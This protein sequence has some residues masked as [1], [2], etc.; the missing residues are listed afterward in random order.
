ML[1]SV[2]LR[3]V[4]PVDEDF[5]FEIFEQSREEEFGLSHWSAGEKDCFLRWQFQLRKTS[6]K[7]QFPASTQWIVLTD[8]RPVGCY[9]VQIDQVEIRLIDL[10]LLIQE[11]GKGIGTV[12]LQRLIEQSIKT[13]KPIRLHVEQ[14]NR[15]LHWYLRLGFRPF[16]QNGIYV[17]LERLSKVGVDLSGGSPG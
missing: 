13:D 2:F 8:Q 10:T 14:T 16:G 7:S 15:A 5:L 17:A 3:P 6:F 12:L 4:Q 1:D 9:E 11:R